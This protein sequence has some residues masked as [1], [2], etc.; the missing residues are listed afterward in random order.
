MD[1]SGS[2]LAHDQAE[3]DVSQE[4]NQV[5]TDEPPSPPWPPRRNLMLEK[6]IAADIDPDYDEWWRK[7]GEEAAVG[8]ARRRES[9]ELYF[10]YGSLMYPRMVQHV[11]QL[12]EPPEMRPAEVV[13]YRVK[14]WGPYPALLHGE[15]GELV[16][17][18]VCEVEGG[19]HKDRLQK[20]E[21]DCYWAARCFV[22]VDGVEEQVAGKTFL[23]SGD[24]DDLD[25]GS[26]DHE[27]W[28]ARMGRIIGAQS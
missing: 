27:S 21:S 2:P 1:G 18:M 25:E 6:F 23:W 16:R 22:R 24:T 13:G 20:Y 28:Q 26:F 8:E 3:E 17:G 5:A 19:E 15:P 4:R 9:K 7:L 10:F 14:M 12:P 11:L